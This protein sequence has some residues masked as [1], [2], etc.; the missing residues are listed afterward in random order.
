[1]GDC[2]NVSACIL[3]LEVDR[4]FCVARLFLFLIQIETTELDQQPTSQLT[5]GAETA[6]YPPS[7]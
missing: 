1:M 5:R 2:T 3:A 7:I 6:T 4:T